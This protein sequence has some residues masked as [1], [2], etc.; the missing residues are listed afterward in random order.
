[1]IS[2]SLSLKLFLFSVFYFEKAEAILDDSQC[3]IGGVVKQKV[4]GV[5][6]IND[7][8]CEGPESFQCGPIFNN[9]CVSSRGNVSV[10]CA[11]AARKEEIP[12]NLES[13]YEEP[14][15]NI[16][17]HFCLGSSSTEC[18]NFGERYEGYK[19]QSF[20]QTPPLQFNTLDNFYPSTSRETSIPVTSSEDDIESL[21]EITEEETET[22]AQPICIDCVIRRDTQAST[23]RQTLEAIENPITEAQAQ[24]W[25]KDLQELDRVS[26][27]SEFVNLLSNNLYENSQCLC[28]GTD[29]CTQGCNDSGKGPPKI[30]CQ[31]RKS[32]AKSKGRCMGHSNNGLMTTLNSYLSDHCKK[33]GEGSNSSR[34]SYN[35]CVAEARKP[36]F[37]P[38]ICQNSLI[39]PHALCALSLHGGKANYSGVQSH[40]RRDC[41][42]WAKYNKHLLDFPIPEE[43]GETKTVS[44]FK[45]IPLEAV[46]KDGKIDPDK[47]PAGAIVV[48]N[49]RSA[50]GHVEIKTNLNECGDSKSTCFCSD[51]CSSRDGQK[52]YEN[53]GLKMRG[54]F[55]INPEIVEYIEGEKSKK[56]DEESLPVPIA[57]LIK[58]ALS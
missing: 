45:Q 3:L 58:K 48:M 30:F 29:V 22:E 26:G 53:Q 24:I 54:I 38:S 36:G 19:R 1:M 52:A 46:K 14:L 33:T 13:Q 12:S 17:D 6:P 50:S 55:V 9:K 5:C 18:K 21:T 34:T 43:S 42:A 41:K 20:N 57:Q 23:L 51:F 40:V 37:E 16:F 4:N 49:S 39:M 31:G 28:G 10:A 44:L 25:K 32:P 11:E 56:P 7:R 35:Q 27:Q 15:E 8:G 47:L 2:S